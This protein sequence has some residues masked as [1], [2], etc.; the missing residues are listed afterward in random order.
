M[1]ARPSASVMVRTAW[2]QFKAVEASSPTLSEKI[3]H[4]IRTGMGHPQ[5]LP[6]VLLS[7]QTTAARVASVSMI[8]SLLRSPPLTPRMYSF[9]TVVSFV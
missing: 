5:G 2:A 9:P 6:R 7:Q 4:E 8:D 3:S 1:E